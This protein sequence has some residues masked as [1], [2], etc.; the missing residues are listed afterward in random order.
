MLKNQSTKKGGERSLK[1]KVKFLSLLFTAWE[2]KTFF[3]GNCLACWLFLLRAWLKVN[4]LV[5]SCLSSVWLTGWFNNVALLVQQWGCTCT[6]WRMH[7]YTWRR[8]FPNWMTI[9]STLFCSQHKNCF[10]SHTCLRVWEWNR[11]KACISWTAQS[12]LWPA[13]M[14]FTCYYSHWCLIQPS[15][16]WYI[17]SISLE[18]P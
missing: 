8:C 9:S 4:F 11:G 10:S 2:D 17:F 3:Q 14:H 16:R 7:I 1:F 18:C 5:P 15:P 6:I 13:L 12:R